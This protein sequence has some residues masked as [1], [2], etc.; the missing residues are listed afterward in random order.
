MQ[1]MFG[2]EGKMV[3]MII[4][5]IREHTACEEHVLQRKTGDYCPTKRRSK[6]MVR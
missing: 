4:M 1:I 5:M 6:T 2:G 3:I